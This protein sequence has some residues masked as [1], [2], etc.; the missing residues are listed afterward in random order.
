MYRSFLEVWEET[1]WK[2]SSFPSAIMR[3]V[4]WRELELSG[5][6]SCY[7]AVDRVGV[8]VV[9]VV[10]VSRRGCLLI[11]PDQARSDCD[12]GWERRLTG[13]QQAV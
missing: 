6:V 5:N 8:V 10:T 12:Q 2:V 1:S 3:V 4:G 13:V 7:S 11:R 9:M